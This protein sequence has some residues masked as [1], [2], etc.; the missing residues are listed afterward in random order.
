M[1]RFVEEAVAQVTARVGVVQPLMVRLPMHSIRLQSKQQ[2]VLR[3][4]LLLP[5]LARQ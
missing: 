1:I 4:V 5:K 3:H 2:L